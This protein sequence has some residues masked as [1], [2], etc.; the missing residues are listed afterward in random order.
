MCYAT[1]FL[2]DGNNSAGQGLQYTSI[3]GSSQSSLFEDLGI[4][5]VTETPGHAIYVGSPTGRQVDTSTFRNITTSNSVDGIY[6]EGTNTLQILYEKMNIQQ[7][8]RH[9]IDLEGGG[10][11]TKD[12]TYLGPFTTSGVNLIQIANFSNYAFFMNDYFEGG[13]TGDTLFYMPGVINVTGPIISIQNGSYSDSIAG[14]TWINYTQNGW[15]TLL[16]NRWSGIKGLAFNFSPLGTIAHT[17]YGT[18][19][20]MGNWYNNNPTFT[21]TQPYALTGLDHTVYV[22]HGLSSVSTPSLESIQ[23]TSLRLI[24]PTIYNASGTQQTN[25]HIVKDTC[26]LGTNCSIA[27]SGGAAF[28]SST[29]YDCWA[30]DA[31]TPANVVTVMRSSGSAVVFA[32]S[33]RDVISFFCAGD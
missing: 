24:T 19:S 7:I 31:T 8:R 6:Q 4:I 5:N 11:T 3:K 30:R 9:F 16:G 2:I 22:N 14:N 13:A 28:T 25:I 10:L 29:S 32:G 18:L 1:G 20:F 27:L 15:L 21:F 23:D 26:T 17:R 33:G 12:N